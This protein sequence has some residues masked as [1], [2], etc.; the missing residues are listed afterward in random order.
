MQTFEIFQ[1]SSIHIKIILQINSTCKL[2]KRQL[3][4]NVAKQGAA[5]IF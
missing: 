5:K 4:N 1:F 2:C 3:S